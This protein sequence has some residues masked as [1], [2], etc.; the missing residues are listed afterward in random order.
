MTPAQLAMT[1]DLEAV[2]RSGEAGQ[3]P[4]RGWPSSDIWPSFKVKG[5]FLGESDAPT[6][7]LNQVLHEPQPQRP[8]QT[9][10]RPACQLAV[11]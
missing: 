2:E 11:G 4:E 10:R 1:I 3:C 9:G 5:A 7:R 8:L 6:Q